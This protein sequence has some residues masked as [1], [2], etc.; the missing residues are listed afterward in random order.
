[1]EGFARRSLVDSNEKSVQKSLQEK[2]LEFKDIS[3]EQAS[4]MARL[5]WMKLNIL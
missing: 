3:P 4:L 2:I 5:F 1:M